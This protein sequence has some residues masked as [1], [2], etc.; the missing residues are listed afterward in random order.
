MRLDGKVPEAKVLA[1]RQLA[2]NM[3]A[4]KVVAVADLTKVRSAQILEVRRKLRGKVELLVTKNTLLRKAGESLEEKR[5]NMAA[6]TGSLTGPNLLLLTDMDPFKLAMFL[7][8][9]KVRVAAKAGEIATG[10]I[11][12]PAGNTGLPPGPII[13]E[14]SEAKIP[15][16]IESGSIWV[17]KDTVVAKRGDVITAKVASVLSKL[18]IKPIEAG[19]SLKAAYEDGL[20]FGQNDLQLDLKRYRDDIVLAVKQALSLSVESS[21]LTKETAPLLLG[22][23]H[24]E[25]MWLAAKSEYPATS[26]MPEI[27]REAFLEMRALSERLALVNKEAAPT[28]YE[29]PAPARVIPP[30]IEPAKPEQVQVEEAKPPEPEAAPPP[31]KMPPPE[32]AEIPET[33]EAEAPPVPA[34]IPKRAEEPVVKKAPAKAAKPRPKKRTTKEKVEKKE[35]AKKGKPKSR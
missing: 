2:E 13:S 16:K 20:I 24:R 18:G 14:F 3:G 30:K 31:E 1:A 27:L 10:D 19:I 25:A 12:V 11:V 32:K 33:P 9:S 29:A 22:K 17:V 15:T 26:I 4:R 34:E 6:F 28:S 8:R 35:K 23:A 5:K 7:E 21:Y